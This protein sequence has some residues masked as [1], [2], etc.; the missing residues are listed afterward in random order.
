MYPDKSDASWP[1]LVKD[2]LMGDE[3]VIE[4]HT[5]GVYYEGLRRWINLDHDTQYAKGKQIN[6]DHNT[7]I[8]KLI[9]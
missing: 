8:D 6:L 4:P 3:L 1:R 5:G 7:Y 2:L 9:F